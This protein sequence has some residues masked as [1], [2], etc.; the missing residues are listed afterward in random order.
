[1]SSVDPP[2]PPP[3]PP[4]PEYQQPHAGGYG[5][6]YA[7]RLG[8]RVVPAPLPEI[9]PALIRPGT[10]W[11]WIAGA[12]GG[13]AI[14]ASTV[15]SFIY[16]FDQLDGEAALGLSAVSWLIYIAGVGLAAIIGGVTWSRRNEQR[17]RLQREELARQGRA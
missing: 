12:I 8:T 15:L 14:L 6:A 9:D 11:Y 2:P 7:G 10:V 13:I 5:Q 4:P 17:R 3:P 1:V 16:S